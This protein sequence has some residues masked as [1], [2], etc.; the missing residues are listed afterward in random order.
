MK[1]SELST[2]FQCGTCHASCPSGR[3][4][5]LNIRKIVRDSVKKDVSDANELWMCTTCFNCQERCP[6]GIKITDAVLTLRSEAARK[7]KILPAHR[8][9]CKFLIETGH[10]IP[11]DEVHITIRE[12]IGLGSPE[13]VYKYPTGLKEIK[14]LLRSTGFDELIKE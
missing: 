3:Y 14:I 6:R 9:V 11:I 8:K 5:S 13:T 2:C 10:S 4:T 1:N 7:G 12:K